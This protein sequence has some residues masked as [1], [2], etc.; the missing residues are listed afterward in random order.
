MTL[1]AAGLDRYGLLSSLDSG[2][3]QLDLLSTRRVPAPVIVKLREAPP[4]LVVLGV[5]GHGVAQQ[6]DALAYIGQVLPAQ[7]VIVGL[8]NLNGDRSPAR[9]PVG[10][11]T[12]GLRCMKA[13]QHAGE[14]E[15]IRYSPR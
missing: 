12:E 7:I 4:G 3:Q 14:K 13:A 10:R 2:A 5:R 11:R 15:R 6:G 8:A 9:R 1:D